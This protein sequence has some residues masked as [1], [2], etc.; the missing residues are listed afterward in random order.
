MSDAARQRHAPLRTHL[1]A[2]D[3]D[4]FFALVADRTISAIAEIAPTE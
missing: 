4:A 1:D 3:A 2:I